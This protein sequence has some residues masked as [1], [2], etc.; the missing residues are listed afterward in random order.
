MLGRLFKRKTYLN[1]T[2][3]IF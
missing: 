2:W 1:F 3:I